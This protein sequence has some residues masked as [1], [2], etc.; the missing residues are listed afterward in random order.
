[1]PSLIHALG[2]AK[3]SFYNQ[4]LST[5][6]YCCIVYVMIT[7]YSVY[8]AAISMVFYTLTWLLGSLYIINKKKDYGC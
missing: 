6:I 7:K 8:G 1:M 3:E 4:S 5:L 2:L